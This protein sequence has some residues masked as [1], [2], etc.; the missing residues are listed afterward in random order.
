MSLNGFAMHV[1]VTAFLQRKGKLHVL[2]LMSFFYEAAKNPVHE[3]TSKE[4]VLPQMPSKAFILPEGPLIFSLGC[5]LY[6]KVN[7]KLK[8]S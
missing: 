6:Q 8:T 2:L 3:S 4:V 7:I 5:F 1:K